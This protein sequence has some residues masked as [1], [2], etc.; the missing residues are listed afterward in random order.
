MTFHD[1][2]PNARDLPLDDPVLR[3]DLVD[4][5]VPLESREA[6]CLALLLLDEEHLCRVPVVVDEMGAPDPASVRDALERLVVE[7]PVPALV[8]A[9]GRQGSHRL[10]DADRACHQAVVEVCR[11]AGVELLGTYLAT[12]CSVEELP[13]HLRMVS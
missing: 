1:L 10:T 11:D 3:A 8:V 12:D 4:L 2:P 9:I 6:G 7:V 13:D 5:V